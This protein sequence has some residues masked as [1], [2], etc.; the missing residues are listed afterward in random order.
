M[1]ANISK[2]PREVVSELDQFIV[3]QH[4]AKRALAV[5]LRNRYRRLL[6]DE[7]MKKEVTP[8]NLLMIG[9]TGVGKTELARRLAKLVDAPFA[10]VEATKFTEVGY[11]GRDVESMV[12]D[13]VENAIQN[14]YKTKTRRSQNLKRLIMPLRN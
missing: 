13:L 1:Q 10:K 5:A 11:V 7:E 12:R 6:L 3:G 8:K 9:P 2:T 14:R 4:D